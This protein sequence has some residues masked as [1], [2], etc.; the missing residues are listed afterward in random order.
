MERDSTGYVTSVEY[1]FKK[2][3][4]LLPTFKK[5]H[6]DSERDKILISPE[7]RHGWNAEH[8]RVNRHSA[9]NQYCGKSLALKLMQIEKD[10]AAYESGAAIAAGK[11]KT[12]KG[13]K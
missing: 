7:R 8:D 13:W 9:G 10:V 1:F 5:C 3:I 2:F 4:I 11:R 6:Y 12:K